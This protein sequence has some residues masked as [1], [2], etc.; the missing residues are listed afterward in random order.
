MDTLAPR[1]W[2]AG[3]AGEEILVSSIKVAQSLLLARDVN[4]TDPIELFAQGRQLSSLRDIS[5]PCSRTPLELTMEVVPLLERE[6][7]NE[8]ADAGETTEEHF[9]LL[10]RF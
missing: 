6:I 7:V 4:C 2:V 9:L 3:P 10:R 8:A 5:K 1:F